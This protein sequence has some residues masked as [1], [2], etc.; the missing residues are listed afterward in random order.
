MILIDLTQK[1]IDE[2][3]GIFADAAGLTQR[4]SPPLVDVRTALESE[5]RRYIVQVASGDELKAELWYTQDPNKNLIF[6]FAF[7]TDLSKANLERAEAAKATFDER[8]QQYLVDYY[9]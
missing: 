3:Y 7:P 2:V 8:L 5:T 6:N 4:Q 9:L 1:I